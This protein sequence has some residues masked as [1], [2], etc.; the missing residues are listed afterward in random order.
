M[1][2]LLS[3]FL[4]IILLPFYII[5][6]KRLG[7]VEKNYKEEL[8]P[9]SFGIFILFIEWLLLILQQQK[10][11][12][13]FWA[14]FLITM[15]GTYDDYYGDKK[16]KGFKGHFSAF[17]QGVITSGF[18]KAVG[19]SIV[20]LFLSFQLAK[21]PFVIGS[22]FFLIVMLSNTM[23]LFD[24]RPGRALK[25]YFVLFL[26]LGVQAPRFFQQELPLIQIG[27]LIIVF[28]YDIRAKIMLGDGGANLLGFQL[29]VWYSI[30]FPLYGK[31]F[32]IIL[33]IGINIYN[34]RHSISQFIEQHKWLRVIDRLG[35]KG[36]G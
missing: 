15:I 25:V 2:M 24:L 22:N 27:I 18:I 1:I 7:K 21:D 14:L 26:L 17:R 30:H 19:V 29:G 33:L 6:L 11:F 20:A 10:E 12:F 4:T 9:T 13:Y 5:F 32:M 31:L 3:M 34:E 36:I 23:N 16:V 28:F 8:I 35:Q